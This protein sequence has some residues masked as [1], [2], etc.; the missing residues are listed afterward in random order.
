MFAEYPQT[1]EIHGAFHKTDIA[2]QIVRTTSIEINIQDRTLLEAISQIVIEIVP[3][4]TQETYNILMI[5]QESLHTNELEIEIMP[6]KI[7][8]LL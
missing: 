6:K 3:L 5:V 1:E 7:A 4:R 8:K 2:D